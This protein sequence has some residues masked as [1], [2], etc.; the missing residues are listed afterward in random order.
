MFTKCVY[1]PSGSIFGNE[2]CDI[3]NAIIIDANIRAYKHV[4]IEKPMIPSKTVTSWGIFIRVKTSLTGD[5][6][7]LIWK[8][9]KT[10]TSEFN[11]VPCIAKMKK[12]KKECKNKSK[13]K[14]K[15]SPIPIVLRAAGVDEFANVVNTIVKIKVDGKSCIEIS[16]IHI[17]SGRWFY[18]DYFEKIVDQN[19]VL[20]DKEWKEIQ[21]S[22]ILSRF[23]NIPANTS[24][25][26]SVTD[27]DLRDLILRRVILEDRDFDGDTVTINGILYF[28][29]CMHG[30]ITTSFQDDTDKSEAPAVDADT[31]ETSDEHLPIPK[32]ADETLDNLVNFITGS[33]K[34]SQ[35]YQDEFRRRFTELYDIHYGREE[36]NNGRDY[37]FDNI[38]KFMEKRNLGFKLKIVSKTDDTPRHWIVIDAYNE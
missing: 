1:D 24:I 6:F 33:K 8:L 11:D 20:E 18:P 21:I 2:L 35:E 4:E 12:K 10:V 29:D 22:N 15:E 26:N 31:P 9:D 36:F 23:E 32:L 13:S 19:S 5:I 30:I 17:K 37:G 38:N 7:D 25:A 27:N 3:D 16:P 14:I 34:I 28:V